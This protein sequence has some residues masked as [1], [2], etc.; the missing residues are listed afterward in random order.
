VSAVRP[1]WAAGLDRCDPPHPPVHA[2]RAPAPRCSSLL[3]FIAWYA[4]LTYT[5]FL[6]V[7]VVPARLLCCRSCRSGLSRRRVL[8]QSFGEFF[9]SFNHLRARREGAV[10]VPI[11]LPSPNAPANLPPPR[12]LAKRLSLFDCRTDS[13]LP[14]VALFRP[15]VISS[16]LAT[17]SLLVPFSRD[18]G[19]IRWG[20]PAFYLDH[21][22]ASG[23]MLLLPLMDRFIVVPERG[24]RRLP[25]RRRLPEHGI[26]IVSSVSRSCPVFRESA[27]A[28]GMPRW[29]SITTHTDCGKL[30][31]VS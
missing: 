15:I 3:R 1:R 28:S 26:R 24:D 13:A 27:R 12:P 20:L 21:P 19:P 22:C 7:A 4:H 23:S 30:F 31:I 6:A 17:T 2:D 5:I 8:S 25:P 29:F 10:L 18:L 9:R 16:F 14:R 11:L